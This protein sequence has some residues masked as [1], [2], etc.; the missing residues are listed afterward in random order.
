MTC[1]TVNINT[2]TALDARGPITPPRRDSALHRGAHT[3]RSVARTTP[4]SR[5]TRGRLPS[6]TPRTPSVVK[7]TT[8]PD[9]EVPETPHSQQE[10]LCNASSGAASDQQH[11]PLPLAQL[12]A[13]PAKS[14]SSVTEPDSSVTEESPA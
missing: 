9:D 14:D 11:D 2:N 13:S 12:V 1:Q 5:P 8:L 6:N 3:R 10:L 4:Y 7:R